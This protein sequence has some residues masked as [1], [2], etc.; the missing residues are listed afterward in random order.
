MAVGQLDGR[1]VVVSGSDDETVRVWD[2][3]TGTPLG[4]PFTGHTDEVSTVAVGQLDGRTVV[5]S[6]GG[7]GTVRVWDA[8]TGDPVGEPF[9]AL[10]R[11]RE[12]G[13][14]RAA[15]RAHRG[16]LRQPRQDSTGVGCGYRRP[17]GRPVYR[18]YRLW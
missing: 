17:A 2:A 5:V 1:T 18:P 14:G 15:G 10:H 13:G 9:T 12:R 8:A 11:R 7:D 16:G 3:A 6:G 4:N